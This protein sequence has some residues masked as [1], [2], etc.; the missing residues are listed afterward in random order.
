MIANHVIRQWLEHSGFAGNL[1]SLFPSHRM[2]KTSSRPRNRSRK[3]EIF[4]S[5]VET[6]LLVVDESFGVGTACGTG[7][8]GCD[9]LIPSIARMSCL[10]WNWRG[11]SSVKITERTHEKRAKTLHRRR[12]GGHPE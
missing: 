5:G 11:R 3:S 8:W 7:S 4:S 9:S 1:L 6:P 2:A 12:E 10:S